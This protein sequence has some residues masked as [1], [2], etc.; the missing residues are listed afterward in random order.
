LPKVPIQI[1]NLILIECNS[2]LKLKLNANV[3]LT[4]LLQAFMKTFLHR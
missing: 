4:L 3:S 1:R 2:R